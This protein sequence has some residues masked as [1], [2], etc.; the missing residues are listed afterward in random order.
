MQRV[1][2]DIVLRQIHNNVL[3]DISDAVAELYCRRRKEQPRRD[4]CLDNSKIGRASTYSIT[5][6]QVGPPTVYQRMNSK[7]DFPLSSSGPYHGALWMWLTL[8]EASV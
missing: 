6:I 4:R 3:R 1:R 7:L 5:I 2:D 8:G